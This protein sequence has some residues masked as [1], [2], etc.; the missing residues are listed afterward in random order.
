[1]FQST[2]MKLGKNIIKFYY[3]HRI[4]YLI[5][6]KKREY[7]IKILLILSIYNASKPGTWNSMFG[8]ERDLRDLVQK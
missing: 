7:N 1:M 8:F 2:I 5:V 4:L 3:W 6:I